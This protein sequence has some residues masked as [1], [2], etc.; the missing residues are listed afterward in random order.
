[1]GFPLKDKKDITITNAFQ[2]FLDESGHRQNKI[3]VDKD[4]GFSIGPMKSWL[5]D[6]DVEIYVTQSEG[7][8]VVAE[9]FIRTLKNNIYRHATTI[10]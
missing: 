6:N 3:W 4:G 10:S 5:Q 1:M 7:K 8:S 9:R 2:I